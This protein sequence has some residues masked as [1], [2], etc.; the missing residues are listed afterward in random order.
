MAVTTAAVIGIVAAAGSSTM[1]FVQAG[2]QKKAQRQAEADADR[3]MQAARQKLE[4]NYYD[5]L[6]VQK[7]PYE[8]ERE[9]LLA[10]GAQAIQ[11][12]VESERGVAATAGRIQMSMNDAQA[13]VRSAMGQELSNLEK[14]KVQED[15]R[16]RDIGTQLDLE[17][18]AGAQLAA[19]NK[20]ELSARSL[21]Q[22]MEGV[23]NLGKQVFKAA[24]LFG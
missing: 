1:S 2:N 3:A 15:S 11:A 19:A 23:T 4:I 21:K 16:L 10:Q 6:A 18:V 12:G 20:E 22:G 7:E 8:L 14:I 24:P 9:A 17:E 5:T 13:G